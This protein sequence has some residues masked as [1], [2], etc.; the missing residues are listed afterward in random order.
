MS[1][2]DLPLVEAKDS[3]KEMSTMSETIVLLKDQ[4]VK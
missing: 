2:Q 1:V 4:V 3:L